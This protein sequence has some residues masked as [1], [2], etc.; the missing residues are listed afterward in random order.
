MRTYSIDDLLHLAALGRFGNEDMNGLAYSAFKRLKTLEY[1]NIQLKQ[2]LEENN[3]SVE[4]FHV[5]Q[6]DVPGAAE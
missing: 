1:E 5:P 3:K 4:F 2:R 6:S